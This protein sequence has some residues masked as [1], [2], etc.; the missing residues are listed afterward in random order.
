M[1][2]SMIAR[3]SFY[4]GLSMISLCC[5][6]RGQESTDGIARG[7]QSLEPPHPQ[8]IILYEDSITGISLP[9]SKGD[10]LGEMRDAFSGYQ[11]SKQVG[12]QDGP[13]FPIYIVAD[14]AEE[15]IVFAMNWQDT[16]QLDVVY[17]KSPVVSDQYGMRI[18]S[19]MVQIQSARNDSLMTQYDY[20]EH[21][22]VYSEDSRIVYDMESTENLSDTVPFANETAPSRAPSSWTI[23]QIIW[24]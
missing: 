14:G 8:M 16:L 3:F 6:Q 22:Y 15:L 18:G 4:V 2:F 7:D 12:Q 5:T 19:N 21:T 13:D 23:R 24:R 11:V 1:A 17:I 20:H 9:F 10:M